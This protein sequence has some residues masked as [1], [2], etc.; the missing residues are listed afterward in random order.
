MDEKQTILTSAKV[1]QSVEAWN[2]ISWSAYQNFCTMERLSQIYVDRRMRYVSRSDWILECDQW[3]V[4]SDFLISFTGIFFPATLNLA[5][6]FYGSTPFNYPASSSPTPTTKF[7]NVT[8]KICKKFISLR[9]FTPICE[10]SVPLSRSGSKDLKRKRTASVAYHL[11]LKHM[12]WGSRPLYIT[13]IELN[14]C[15]TKA[16][17]PRQLLLTEH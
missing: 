10:L 17:F 14:C 1:S 12:S 16:M 7:S 11:R 3:Y 8:L 9:K 2:T 5:Q 13:W 6:A 15:P 4:S